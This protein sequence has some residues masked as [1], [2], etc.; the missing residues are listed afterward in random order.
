MKFNK[1][2]VLH[3]EWN[4]PMQQQ[5]LGAISVRARD[6]LTYKIAQAGTLLL[7]VHSGRTRGNRHS[8][9]PG[10][11]SLN[12]GKRIFT[13]KVVRHWRRCPEQLWNLH[14]WGRA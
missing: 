13:M 1:G 11:F 12:T 10:N 8:M 9:K 2:K 3:Q 7:E 6:H 14:N 5:R 4:N